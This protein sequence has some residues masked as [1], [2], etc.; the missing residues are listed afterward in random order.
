MVLKK[1]NGLT[2]QPRIDLVSQI[3]DRRLSNVLDL[4]GPQVLRESLREEKNNERDGKDWPNVVEGRL[5]EEIIQVNDPAS[6]GYGT[7]R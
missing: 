7:K 1:A 6:S 4:R 2:N 3:G 5:R